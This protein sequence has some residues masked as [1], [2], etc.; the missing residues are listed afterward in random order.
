MTTYRHTRVIALTIALL[1][2]LT[3]F[4]PIS[5]AA[6]AQTTGSVNV[7]SG[8]GT[9]YKA[10][11]KVKTGTQVEV[12]DNT[13]NPEWWKIKVNG[14]EGYITSEYLVLTTSNTA[15]TTEKTIM[16]AEA[17]SSYR[18][19]AT[20][21]SGTQVTVLD[22][23]T[24]PGWWKVSYNEKE[25]YV[26]AR[27]LQ[28]GKAAAP[29]AGQPDAQA[30][31]PTP[32]PAATNQ[33]TTAD[34]VS[35]GDPNASKI[36]EAKKINSDTVGWISVPNTN[37]SDP[38]LYRANFYYQNRNI[39]KKKSLEGVYPYYSFKQKNVVIF[40]HN[41]RGSG[42]GFHQL[43][44]LQEAATGS[45]KCKYSAC[46]K[47][48]SDLSGWYKKDSGR[49]WNISI[50]GTSKWEV[51]AMYEVPKNEKIETLRNNWNPLTGYSQQSVQSW[52]DGQIKRSEIN[53][54]VSVSGS[55]QLMTIITCGTNYDSATANSR[56]F[57]FLKNVG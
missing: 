8:P 11:T 24:V 44:H 49:I 34:Q 22:N 33:N 40:G 35:A 55:D 28:Y 43:H 39:Y 12:L 38:I 9:N 19:L 17:G 15:V 20:L 53:F 14:K 37:I 30:N 23:A 57:V 46:K 48:I 2:L 31:A 52:I 51:F 36:A 6:S 27:A 5:M 25:G 21:E 10:I 47:S 29:A 32:T 16:R 50:Y 56:L 54:G 45:S 7:R 41:L 18:T 3:C 13:T 4:A 1:V 42:K 26:E